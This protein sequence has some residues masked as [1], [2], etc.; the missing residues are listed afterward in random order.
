MPERYIRENI[1]S[2]TNDK[3]EQQKIIEHDYS[4]IAGEKSEQ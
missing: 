4:E 3:G 2:S 1:P